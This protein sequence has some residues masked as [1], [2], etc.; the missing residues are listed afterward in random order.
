M[1]LHETRTFSLRQLS[2]KSM[3]SC[4]NK[5]CHGVTSSTGSVKL[6]KLRNT[7]VIVYHCVKSDERQY[8]YAG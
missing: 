4:V 7:T 5:A 8:W 3:Y 6:D 2:L 1:V